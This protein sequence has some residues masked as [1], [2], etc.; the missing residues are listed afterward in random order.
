MPITQRQIADATG[1][2]EATVSRVLSGKDNVRQEV[3]NQI[4]AAAR[5]LEYRGLPRRVLLICETLVPS[6]Y[7]AT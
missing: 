3:R 2:S 7:Y 4:L 1:F 6:T 5:T